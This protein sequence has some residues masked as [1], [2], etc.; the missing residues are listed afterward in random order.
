[1]CNQCECEN[2]QLCSIKGYMPHGSCCEK[3]INYNKKHSCPYYQ[4]E[5]PKIEVKTSEKFEVMPQKLIKLYP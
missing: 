3:C 2:E 1:M 4:L 5:M